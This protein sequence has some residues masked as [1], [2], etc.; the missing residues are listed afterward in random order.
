MQQKNFACTQQTYI[1]VTTYIF[2][3]S[4]KIH[5]YLQVWIHLHKYKHL[6][7]YYIL[8][9]YI[10]TIWI[11]TIIKTY[12]YY[13]RIYTTPDGN[14]ARD[15]RIRIRGWHCERW[16][17][18]SDDASQHVAPPSYQSW[19]NLIQPDLE[20]KHQYRDMIH[21]SIAEYWNY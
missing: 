21:P 11:H 13:I 7:T 8:Y 5:T 20:F 17:I 6:H 10:K 1:W 2:I 14:Q 3:H 4:D 12:I 19:I 15:P 9:V 16:W 18:L